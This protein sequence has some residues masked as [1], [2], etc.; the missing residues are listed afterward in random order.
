M[1]AQAVTLHLETPRENGIPQ[2]RPINKLLHGH[3]KL[4][5]VRVIAALGAVPDDI[6]PRL[7]L[8][9]SLTNSRNVIR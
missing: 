1:L 6:T 9:A 5:R 2:W 4:S 8:V 7:A 3:I